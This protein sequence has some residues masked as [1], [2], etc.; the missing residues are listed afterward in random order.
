MTP[1]F[2]RRPSGLT[3]VTTSPRRIRWGV[4]TLTRVVG[5]RGAALLETCSPLISREGFHAEAQRRKDA[6][7]PPLR[8][9][10]KTSVP[11]PYFR[12]SGS[13]HRRASRRV[14]VHREGGPRLEAENRERREGDEQER[15]AG[16]E[17][18]LAVRET[19]RFGISVLHLQRGPGR[20]AIALHAVNPNTIVRANRDGAQERAGDPGRVACS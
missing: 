16:G 4:L 20:I 7:N 14:C 6:E 10:V 19:L 15:H 9:C 2:D 1:G 18:P 13:D 5:L 3:T 8:L 11:F 12:R 17:G